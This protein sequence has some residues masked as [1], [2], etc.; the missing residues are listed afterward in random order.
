MAEKITALAEAVSTIVEKLAGKGSDLVLS[1]E[2]LTVDIAGR[3]VKINGRIRI[4]VVYVREAQ[5]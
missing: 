3:P 1:L 5:E 2:D 4:D